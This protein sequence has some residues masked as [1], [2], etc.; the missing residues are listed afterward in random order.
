MTTT[1]KEGEPIVFGEKVDPKQEAVYHARIEAAKKSGGVNA[2]KGSTP[3]GHMERPSIPPLTRQVSEAAEQS[4]GLVDGG[5]KARPPGSPVLSPATEAQLADAARAAK[6]QEAAAAQEASKEPS[7]DKTEGLF[8]MLDFDGRSEAERI[9]N[10]KKRRQEIEIRCEPMSF[11]DLLMKNEV[12]Q[13]VPIIPGKFEVIFRSMVPAESLFVKQFMSAESQ[14][15]ENYYLEKMSMCNIAIGLLSI[16][17]KPIGAPHLND[18]EVN[19]EVFKQKLK[20]LSKKSA[21]ILADLS[22]NYA[23]FDLRVRRLLSPE[24]LGNG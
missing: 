17:G 2:L 7:E 10:N 13:I 11:E 23:W 8:D 16:N 5:V 19:E 1:K 24:K 12:H 21:Y 6:I 20:S 22:L 14:K 4:D 9:L 15:S 3:L 18:D